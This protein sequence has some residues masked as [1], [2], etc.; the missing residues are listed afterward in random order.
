MLCL[1]FVPL[2]ALVL[3]AAFSQDTPKK[4]CTLSKYG[5]PVPHE[6][7]AVWKMKKEFEAIVTSSGFKCNTTLFHQKWETAE[8][9]VEDRLTLVK[10]ELDLAVTVLEAS[11]TTRLP[12]F[13]QPLAFLTQA[14]KDVQDCVSVLPPSPEPSGK[15]KR[16]LHKLEMAKNS[17]TNGLKACTIF[18]LFQF[19]Y[20]L[21]CA[22][23]Q[24]QCTTKA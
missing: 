5:F 6:L 8:L 11:P 23:L 15:L 19:L 1:N 2:L 14:Q 22:A 17:E 16:W 13:F 20:D 4:R 24:K 7:Q 10:A 21:K 9:S 3:G 18:H 12:I